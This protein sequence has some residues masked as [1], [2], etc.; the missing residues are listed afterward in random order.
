MVI[1]SFTP[2]PKVNSIN[3][4][5]T[6]PCLGL[7]LLRITRLGSSSPGT[8]KQLPMERKTKRVDERAPKNQ[9]LQTAANAE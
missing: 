7:L 5:C 1:L 2:L 3:E 8:C 4:N 6:A 9:L